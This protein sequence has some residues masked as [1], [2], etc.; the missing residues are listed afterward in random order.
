MNK[1]DIIVAEL[2]GVKISFGKNCVHIEN[3]YQV[4]DDNEKAKIIKGI[5]VLCPN[6]KEFRTLENMLTEWKAHNIMFQ[7]K[8]KQ[9]HTKDVDFEYKQNKLHGICFK[10]ITV[11]FKEKK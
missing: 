4:K 3:S 2:K 8:F 7:H 9:D 11:F 10:L 6:I 1:K 5:F